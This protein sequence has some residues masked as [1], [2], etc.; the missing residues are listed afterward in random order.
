M[1]QDPLHFENGN[2]VCEQCGMENPDFEHLDVHH[3]NPWLTREEVEE[4][5]VGIR[6]ATALVR[7]AEAKGRIKRK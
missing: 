6:K 5:A 1:T 2:Q 4:R 7:N 3:R